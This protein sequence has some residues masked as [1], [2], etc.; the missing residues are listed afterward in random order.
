MR[1]VSSQPFHTWPPL[2]GHGTTSTTHHHDTSRLLMSALA[3]RKRASVSVELLELHKEE[4]VEPLPES[5][6][7]VAPEFS[8]ENR[9]ASP[10]GL[11]GVVI[12]S[13]F[14]FYAV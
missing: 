7:L 2:I 1:R 5:L 8:R 12:G 9:G 11:E 13:F 6:Y 10:V 3:L 14:L 4:P